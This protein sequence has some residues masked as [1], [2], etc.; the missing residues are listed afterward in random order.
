[1]YMD[2]SIPEDAFRLAPNLRQLDKYEL[3]LMGRDPL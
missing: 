2:I 1:M 3:A